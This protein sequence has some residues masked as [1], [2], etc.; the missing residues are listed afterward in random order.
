MT[1]R[2]IISPA[3]RSDLDLIWEYYAVE[4]QNPEIADRINDEL[5]QAMRKLAI[6]PGMGHLRNDLA[7]E[8]LRFWCVRS[9]L[10]IYRCKPS[11][12][13]EIVRILH[14]ARDV[15]AILNPDK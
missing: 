8:L 6:T 13:L 3:A 1:S 4:I 7:R 5:F 10:I 2:F 12:P 14:G 15:R 9:Y 11:A